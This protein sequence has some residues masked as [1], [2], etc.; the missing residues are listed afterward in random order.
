M[1]IRAG[2]VVHV[3]GNQFVAKSVIDRLQTVGP[4]INI[5]SEKVYETGNFSAVADVRD[6][7]ELTFG[8]ESVDVSTE[9][10][11]LLA[12][13]D[14]TA[15]ADGTGFVLANS[16]PL[17]I[18]SPYKA[19]LNLYNITKSIALP[20]L[21]LSS[22]TYRFGVQANAT[23][24]FEMAGD[25]IYYVNGSTYHEVFAEAGAGPYS[26]ANGPAIVTN[27]SGVALYAYCVTS[28]RADGTTQRLFPVQDYTNTTT[29]FTLTAA[30]QVAA[31]DGFLHVVYGSGVADTYPE[32][33]HQGVGVKP[34]AVRGSHIDVYVS[35]GAATPTLIKWEG[36]QSAE[37]TWR[38][39]LEA[40]R[41]LGNTHIVEQSYDV[42]DLTGTLTM[43]P[44]DVNYM[45]ARVSQV[46]GVPVTETINALS[47]VAL[48]THIRI[49]HPISGVVLKTLVAEKCR[50]TPPAGQTQ[51]NSRVDVPFPFT[52]D[53]GKLTVYKGTAPF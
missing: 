27:E 28:H 35:D 33:V 16:K 50:Y 24:S 21:T 42:P 4:G 47:S 32:A 49:R 44:K 37:C 22:A 2:Q 7:P 43:R 52:S 30:G 18:L 38:L 17:D 15:V 13:V 34:A 20:Y 19:A 39:A 45:F 48:D 26:F 3:A 12:G 46:T 29:G 41:E 36:L 8:V 5:P 6:T 1:T 25:S 31:P 53:T 10:E 9:F 14:P 11:A 40:V 51:A 23:Q